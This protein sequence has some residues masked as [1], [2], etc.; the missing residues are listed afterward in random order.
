[1]SRLI[2]ANEDLLPEVAK[3]LAEGLIVTLPVKGNSMLP[4]IMG[5]QD[6]VILHKPSGPLEKWEIVL[7]RTNAG[8]YVLHRIIACNEKDI[9]LMGDG[10]LH[11]KE[12]CSRKNVF[13]VVKNIIKGERCINCEGFAQR[14]KAKLWYMMLPM[15]KYILALCRH[16]ILK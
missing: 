11:G 14:R 13:G 3:M 6:S 12:I 5:G 1:M 10:N 4:F 8:A 7:A 15:R 2:I 16:T 9:I